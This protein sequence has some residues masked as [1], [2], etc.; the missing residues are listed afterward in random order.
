MATL[1]PTPLA[2]QAA[3]PASPAMGAADPIR[4]HFEA[5]NA[6]AMA[7][8]YLRQPGPVNVPGAT[9]KAVQAL[10]A[11]RIMGDGAGLSAAIGGRGGA[12]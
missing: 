12:A 6:L 5:H 1:N 4:L 3:A 11:L 10:A 2:A 7:L 8:H 9:R